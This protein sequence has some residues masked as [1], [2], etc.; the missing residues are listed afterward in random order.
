M[1][2]KSLKKFRGIELQEIPWKTRHVIQKFLHSFVS[3]RWIPCTP[4]HLPDDDVDALISK[5]PKI[6]F[7]ALLP[8]QLDG[9]RYG[10]RR[11]GC[12][13]IAD[14]MGLGKT[15]QAIAIACCFINEGPFLVVCPAILRFSWAEELER[16]L[17]FCSPTDIHLVFGHHDNPAHL[18]RCP[19]VVVISYKMLHHLRKSIL[20]QEWALLIVDESHHIRC[21]K[22]SSEPE[23]I[24]AVLD[25]A[26]KVKRKVLLSGTPSLSRLPFDIFHQINILW[27]GLLGT[28]KY[29]F[30]KTYCALKLVHGSQGNFQD[31]S[32]GI[33]LEE[34][35][36]LLK[37]TVMIRRL[38]EHVLLQLPPKRRQVIR[39]VLTK[40][41]ITSALAATKMDD[42]G[43]TGSDQEVGP[44]MN[45]CTSETDSERDERLEI[46]DENKDKICCDKS[47][48]LLS[49]Q[50]LG[51]AK[52]SGFR[53]WISI[54]PIVTELESSENLD[55]DLSSQKMIIFAHHLKVL[56]GVQEIICEKGIGF[57]RI[58][59]NTLARDRQSAV[60]AFQS[61]AEARITF[62]LQILVKIAII[63]ITAGGV[64]LDFSLARNVFLE[65]R[66]TSSDMVQAEDRA[67]KR[68][69]T[70]AVNIYI[71]CAKD[72]SDESIWLSLNKSLRKVSS[73][74]NG[75]YDAVQAIAVARVSDLGFEGAVAQYENL[76]GSET[77]DLYP[78]APGSNPVSETDNI[79]GKEGLTENA[80][81]D[82]LSEVELPISHETAV[83]LTM[84]PVGRYEEISEKNKDKSDKHVEADPNS[85]KQNYS[86]HVKGG[87]MYD[88]EILEDSVTNRGVEDPTYEVSRFGSLE[89]A[90][91]MDN[92]TNKR[93]GL[94]HVVL[95]G[96]SVHS[97]EAKISQNTTVIL[98]ANKM[99]TETSERHESEPAELTVADESYSIQA[100]DLRFEVSQYTGRIHLYTCIPGKDSRPRLLCKNFRPEEL[101]SLN[102]S[103]ADI[104]KKTD[105]E[106]IKENQ[107]CKDILLTFMKEW[108]DLRPIDRKKLL[109]KP[110]Q[111]PLSS[112]LWYLK[113]RINHGSGGLLKG[114]S[115][116]RATP[117]NDISHPLPANA[118]WKKISLCSGRKKDK[119]YTQGWTMT[120][121]PLCKLCQTPC[122][123]KLS[124]TPEF[125]EDL[126]CNLACLQEYR[127]RTSRRS[128]R[129]E[130][131]NTEHGVCVVCNL[132]CH[133]LI[134][135]IRPLR[136]VAG[137]R[138]YVEK[139]A[140][141]LASHKNLL[142]KLVNDPIEGNAWHADHIIP[143]HRGGGECNL[144]NMRTLCVA[145]HRD[146][147]KAQG[148]E[149]RL[150]RIRAKKRV[151]GILKDLKDGD[152]M[153]QTNYS[154]KDQEGLEMREK[155][156]ED[157][158]L[159]KVPGSAYSRGNSSVTESNKENSSTQAE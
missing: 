21:S 103:A 76:D 57:V 153:E 131:F 41:D 43:Y 60:R 136:S 70:N 125:F 126:F 55:V 44:M 20:E 8:F 143:V 91:K 84:Q 96:I 93:K 80:K 115:K 102:F 144:D 146:V 30:A 97:V 10:L 138:E 88:A 87:T 6:L 86:P 157:E 18:S 81:C 9:V 63:G 142:D 31:F 4:E 132:D 59:G 133:K 22:K 140:P 42:I 105:E 2:V 28:S 130:V 16:W 137:R 85:S 11:G 158:L 89:T 148:N 123:G 141:K 73:V 92:A 156:D 51:I 120:G 69:Q 67:H 29:D 36:V 71:F 112:E 135:C 56:D 62:L 99:Y 159:I 50:Q 95:E 121:E 78:R 83:T 14:E 149:R 113:E 33:R 54:H 79:T 114:G 151:K 47:S 147:T 98:K 107:A 145:C 150:K 134:Q 152:S 109:G 90:S 66:R 64:G 38:K 24:K 111:L 68:G 100:D 23:E 48:R 154:S 61:S 58:D 1:V 35:N 124:K 40:S 49:N 94:E 74:M 27:P 155:E 101:E 32:Q 39:L 110:L 82:E 34:L 12:C 119:E 26:T 25:V 117:L 52:L 15:I 17:P 46:S 19:R 128:L 77:G 116:R 104:S 5:L 45:D 127:I 122:K 75:K 139:V 72:T 53:E 129:E 106:F 108:N 3:E 118:L 13:L 7:D 65:L 37:Q